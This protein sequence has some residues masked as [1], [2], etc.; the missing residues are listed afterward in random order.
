LFRRRESGEDTRLEPAPARS[1]GFVQH[2][3]ASFDPFVRSPHEARAE[4]PPTSRRAPIDVARISP[5]GEA[6]TRERG[7]VT[8]LA[9]ERRS[10]GARSPPTG[11]VTRTRL[12]VRSA[13][14]RS[15]RTESLPVRPA[16]RLERAL[17]S[18]ALPLCASAAAA[19]SAAR[20]PCLAFTADAGR[21]RPVCRD[22]P[23]GRGGV[24]FMRAR[25]LRYAPWIEAPRAEIGIDTSRKRPCAKAN[26]IG[27]A[28]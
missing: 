26:R 13:M 4:P 24:V 9:G 21:R 19:L 16:V 11:D 5:A 6:R 7:R 10:H 25:G 28:P 12:R 8:E 1:R 23:Q 3:R 2:G 15:T 14:R 18:S 22:S 27:A 20:A 17:Q